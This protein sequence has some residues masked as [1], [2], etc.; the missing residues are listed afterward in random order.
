MKT[1]IKFFSILLTFF[2][3]QDATSQQITYSGPVEYKQIVTKIANGS[4]SDKGYNWNVNVD[5]KYIIEGTFYVT[6]TGGVSPAGVAMFQLTSVEENIHFENSVNNEAN[7]EVISQPC[8]D[9]KMKFTR[10]VSPGDSRTDRLAVNS[11]RS[12]TEKPCITGGY[13]SIICPPSYN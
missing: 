1:G 9:G 11:I 8:F 12:N 5:E 6:F 3:I 4:G 10:N 2:V 7:E 13:L